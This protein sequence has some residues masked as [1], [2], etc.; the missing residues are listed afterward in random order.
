MIKQRTIKKPIF[1][2][3][4]GLHNG[5]PVTATFLPAPPNT[6]TVFRRVDIP[7]QQDIPALFDNVVST[8]MATKLS[9]H[10]H[11]V[12]TVEHLLSALFGCGIDN[13]IV[14]IDSDEVPIMDGSSSVFVGMI[15]AAGVAEQNEPKK[16]TKISKPCWIG[17][18]SAWVSL[19]PYDGF[20][21]SFTIEFDHP[22]FAL[23]P[24]SME[25]E[26]SVDEYFNKI[27]QA[28]TFGFAK[29]IK[30]M[31][32]KNLAIGGGVIN[33]IVLDEKKVVNQEGLRFHDELLRHKVLDA[34]GDLYLLGGNIIGKF[35]GYKSGHRLTNALLRKLRKDPTAVEIITFD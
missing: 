31:R 33:A 29:D 28:R 7:D 6:G 1:V 30:Q 8:D 14:E 20:N 22:I 10:S 5:K 25:F 35:S 9:S 16:Y 13:L 19:E 23:G 2:R 17:D 3:G 4:V 15:Q 27:S 21:V 24:Q 34:L 11:T 12:S 18:D 32:A 26:Y